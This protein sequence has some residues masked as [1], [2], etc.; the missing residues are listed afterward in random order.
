MGYMS[1][2]DERPGG[3]CRPPPTRRFKQS[4]DPLSFAELEELRRQFIRDED[5]SALYNVEDR[6]LG[7]GGFGVVRRGSRRSDGYPVALK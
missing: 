4:T 6:L 3:I 7:T 1:G 2:V 5:A